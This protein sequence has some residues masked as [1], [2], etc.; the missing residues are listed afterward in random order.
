MFKFLG[1]LTN[2]VVEHYYTNH[3]ISF[4]IESP[5]VAEE[6]FT[7][8]LLNSIFD[9]KA[10]FAQTLHSL[11]LFQ[12][13]LE[14]PS[15]ETAGPLKLLL[16]RRKY[17]C[18]KLLTPG[19]ID[20]FLE[21]SRSL[22]MTHSLNG[23]ENEESQDFENQNL[24]LDLNGQPNRN[25][26]PLSPNYKSKKKKENKNWR[27]NIDHDD[28]AQ[29]YDHNPGSTLQ[30]PEDDL[31]QGSLKT[32]TKTKV[33]DFACLEEDS[34]RQQCK[35]GKKPERKIFND[36]NVPQIGKESQGKWIPGHIGDSRPDKKMKYE[37]ISQENALKGRN[38]LYFSQP[39]TRMISA[40]VTELEDENLSLRKQLAALQS[41]NKEILSELGEVTVEKTAKENEERKSEH[42]RHIFQSPSQERSAMSN[43]RKPR[44][45]EFG[46]NGENG[47]QGYLVANGSSRPPISSNKSRN[48]PVLNSSS[49][50]EAASSRG[51]LVNGAE[52]LVPDNNHEP[53]GVANVRNDENERT[54]QARNQ[55]SNTVNGFEQT[56]TVQ[57][58]ASIQSTENS[59]GGEGSS[60]SG[61][62]EGTRDQASASQR[63]LSFSVQQDDSGR[64]S[65][66][67]RNI[68]PTSV[69]TTLY[70]NYKLLLLSL[71]QNLLSS[72]VMLLQDWTAQNFSINNPRNATDILFQLDEKG[73]IN[74]SDLH[75]LS[76]FFESIVRFD[77]VHII[78]A[79]LLGD[80]DLLRQSQAS[81]KHAANLVQNHGRRA[82]TR[83]PGFLNAMNSGQ[84][85]M[86]TSRNLSRAPVNSGVH[87]SLPSTQP[88]SS[89]SFSDTSNSTRS[90]VRSLRNQSSA[91][92]QQNPGKPAGGF[93]SVRMAEVTVNADGPVTSKCTCSFSYFDRF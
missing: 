62:V 23:K 45:N 91:S 75:Q 28:V 1:G 34:N 80:Y 41:I 33:Q 87:N 31:V 73:V 68:P 64:E 89:R 8:E 69:A 24:D 67:L 65:I 22:L 16:D 88:Q 32:K 14:R 9:I 72:D 82:I 56:A 29:T 42:F 17:S 21:A 50:D 92:E 77:L 52:A 86:N 11:D 90:S 6:K 51:H 47:D 78:D 93:N 74:A 60:P 2:K 46:N 39:S 43:S 15:E 4:N 25:S 70:N 48:P 84:F 3:L 12:S 58:T 37:K 30:K 71:A 57:N 35:K 20:S 44:S 49:V 13:Y 40:R 61:N 55:E 85:S 83:N 66:S 36:I 81:K 38:S 5:N 76:D 10:V 19:E 27:G 79:F 63:G 7:K 26:P 18:T 53:G 59:S 54:F